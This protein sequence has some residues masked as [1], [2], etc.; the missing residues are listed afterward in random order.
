MHFWILAEVH[1][2][3]QKVEQSLEALKLCH[4]QK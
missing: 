4:K 3:P 1:N 2:R